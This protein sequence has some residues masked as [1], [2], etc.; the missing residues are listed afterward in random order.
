[1]LRGTHEH[2][3]DQKGRI[4]L[5][6]RFR[7]EL[8]RLYRNESVVITVHLTDPCLVVYPLTEWENFE[9]RLSKFPQFEPTLMALRRSYLSRAE[10]LTLDKQGRLLIPP[11][12]RAAAAIERDA[13]WA[14][15]SL[16]AELWAKD[17]HEQLVEPLRSKIAAGELPNVLQKL[18]E[19]GI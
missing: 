14:G 10:Q 8:K 7:E 17:K 13:V 2:A 3:V 9:K 6:I 15:Q 12:L 19:L 5:P 4:A 18:A 16:F 11:K 1:M